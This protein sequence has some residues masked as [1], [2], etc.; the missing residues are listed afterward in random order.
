VVTYDEAGRA[1]LE[2]QEVVTRLLALHEELAHGDIVEVVDRWTGRGYPGH[3]L[4]S[5]AFTKVGSCAAPGAQPPS[6]G[7]WSAPAGLALLGPGP[8]GTDAAR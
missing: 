5:C 8:V 6:L 3:M 4:A 7:S 2:R 1:A